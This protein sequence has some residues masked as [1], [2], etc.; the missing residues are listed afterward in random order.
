M[1]SRFLYAG[2]VLILLQA[3]G[4]G[5]AFAASPVVVVSAENFYGSLVQQIGGDRVS[6]TSILS[7]PGVDPHQYEST[8]TDARAVAGADLVVENGGGYDDWMDRLLSASP[9]SGRVVIKGFDTAVRRLPDNVHVWYDVDNMQIISDA[10]AQ[11]LRS[12]D[13]SGASVYDANAR[14]LRRS[15]SQ[16]KERLVVAGAHLAGTPVG[17]TESLFQYQVTTLR[18]TVLTPFA[19]QK[20]IAEGTDPPADAAV[21]VENQIRQHK[22]RLLIYNQQTLSPVVTALE[23]AA[24]AAG[25]PTVGVTE[26]MPPGLTYQG[27][28]LA[29]VDRLTAA[30]SG[31]P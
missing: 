27:W 11:G 17:L 24:S 13:P 23:D 30:L 20:A 8:V 6:V 25:I 26:T 7:D 4:G 2:A 14:E 18:L 10:I 22:I 29:Q 5:S 19:F 15:L 3:A 12:L 16:L 21:Q 9:R 31:A 1:R 28:M